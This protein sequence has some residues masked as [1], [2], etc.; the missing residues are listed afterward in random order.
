MRTLITGAS[1]FVG[2]HLLQSLPIAFALTRADADLRKPLPSLPRVD[3]VFH[4]ASAIDDVAEM[5]AVNVDGTRRLIEWAQSSGVRRFV[6]LSS[7]GVSG[8]GPY[9]ESKRA[10]EEIAREAMSRMDVQ[11]VRLFFPYG[12]RQ[13]QPRLVPRLIANVREGVPIQTT[14]NGPRL[15]LTFI[16]DVIEGLLRIARTNGSHVVDLGGPAMSMREIGETIGGMLGIAPKFETTATVARDWI[17]DSTAI[18]AL[19]GFTPETSFA[20]GLTRLV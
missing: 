16:N 2:S 6:L 3:V 18:R 8:D 12:P 4:C 15:S 20:E 13:R 14:E 11:I 7:G 5:Q 9:A 17:A 1:G 19:T 10:A